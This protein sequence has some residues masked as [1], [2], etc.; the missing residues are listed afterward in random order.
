MAIGV[1]LGGRS[2]YPCT[3]TVSASINNGYSYDEAEVIISATATFNKNTWTQSS[4]AAISSTCDGQSQG[5]ISLIGNTHGGARHSYPNAYSAS[6]VYH[7]SRG[8]GDRQ[9][10]WSLTVY[11]SYDMANLTPAGTESGALGVI[12]NIPLFAC[13]I[14]VMN[15]A[16]EQDMISG[17]FSY[18]LDEGGNWQTGMVNEP[19][20]ATGPIYQEGQKHWFKDIVPAVGYKL[21]SVTA[22]TGDVSFEDD[23]YKFV[24]PAANSVVTIQMQVITYTVHYDAGSGTGA[25][26]DQTKNYGEPLVL[27]EDTP[28]R[29]NYE[30][31]GWSK[32]QDASVVTYS[33]GDTYSDN[34]DLTLYAVWKPIYW[35]PRITNVVLERCDQDG[36]PDEYGTYLDVE[37]NYECCQIITATTAASASIGYL[38]KGK[39]EEYTPI[40]LTIK[41]AASGSV[42]QLVG[43]GGIFGVDDAY[44]L[45]IQVTDS[46]GG[47]G[48]YFGT[49]GASKF[50][51][52]FKADG[53]GVA[54]GRPA[55]NPGF[56]VAMESTFEEN[57]YTDKAIML[58]TDETPD[59]S[60]PVYTDIL[61]MIYPVGSIYISTKDVSPQDLFKIG[62]WQKIENRFLLAAGDVEAGTEGG[63]SQYALRANI[64][65][66]NAN[67][68]TIGYN[69]AVMTEYQ[70]VNPC[71]YTITGATWTGDPLPFS[72]STP[73]TEESS[74]DIITTIMPPYLAVYMWQR[75]S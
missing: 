10:S 45:R 2:S 23:I 58:K 64:G 69:A 11:S 35:V 47:T 51:L 67:P 56:D 50:I 46:S 42:K 5:A 65:A 25:P 18:S 9:I 20:G 21:E 68:S 7:V 41:A 24:Q 48:T 6:Q 72:H 44:D 62:I 15:P 39:D 16:G 73:V 74:T 17:T 63:K 14:N 37:F 66:A 54:I 40:N 27:S 29:T 19:G 59:D 52:D 30:F 55:S 1:Y 49:I 12:G 57:V 26:D 38:R 32:I 43:D 75:I 22:D 31:L 34:A 3:V 4:G 53:D 60:Q 13:D 70:R 28:T 33:P 61:D 36:N 8:G 71:S